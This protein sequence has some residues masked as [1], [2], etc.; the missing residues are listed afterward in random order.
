M[1]VFTLTAWLL[2]PLWLTAQKKITE[3]GD[4]RTANFYYYSAI[5]NNHYTY[6]REDNIQREIHKES[7][8]TSIW[9]ILWK[10]DCE[11][12]LEYISGNKIFDALDKKEV[13]QINVV[14]KVVEVTKEYYRYETYRS[15]KQTLIT[16]DTLWR[17]EQIAKLRRKNIE[18][19]SFPG[20]TQGWNAYL[21]KVFT[22]H[23]K[24]LQKAKEGTYFISFVVDTDGSVSE[25][26]AINKQNSV[27][28][29]IAIGAILNGPK[30]KPATKDGVPVKAIKTQPVVF[31][32]AK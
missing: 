30:W 32:F 3:C 20:G 1:K 10:N 19:S 13:D 15:V 7:G 16:S 24:Q 21:T 14:V 26:K 8:D 27:I 12:I 28:A 6:I 11:Y 29:K 31:E 9:R 18:E 25:V 5:D 23:E 22:E 4:L 2:I 17:N